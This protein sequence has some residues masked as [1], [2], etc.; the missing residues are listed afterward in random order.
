M[1]QRKRASNP[2][3][4]RL[5]IE[6]K[7]DKLAEDIKKLPEKR[8]AMLEELMQKK[9]ID[10][11]EACIILGVSLPSL[12]RAIAIKRIRTVKLGRYLRIPADEIH[13]L[14]EESEQT[15]SVLEAAEVLGIKTTLLR[16]LL[17]SG[18]VK[19]FRFADAGRFRIPKHEIDRLLSEGVVDDE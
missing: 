19:G 1:E 9:L 15:L 7:L 12:R 16:S 14:V 4:G 5:N 13:R 11:P 18:K 8:K 2:S 17:K 10:L 6:K 3:E